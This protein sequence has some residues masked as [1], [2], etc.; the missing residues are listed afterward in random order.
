MSKQLHNYYL[1]KM[2]QANQKTTN[3]IFS[4]VEFLFLFKDLKT[5]DHLKKYEADFTIHYL[6]Y[7]TTF[8]HFISAKIIL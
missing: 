5:G 7:I 8:L 3:T 6:L 2:A 4:T 1:I